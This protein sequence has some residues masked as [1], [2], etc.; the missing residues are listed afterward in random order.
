M[1]Q[2]L[3]DVRSRSPERLAR[4]FFQAALAVFA[5]AAALAW[6]L[7]ALLPLP[8]AEAGVRFPAAF[9]VSSLLLWLGSF[10]LHRAVWQVRRERQRPFRRALLAALAAG[11][12]FI[13]VQSFG[14]YGLLQQRSLANVTTGAG[15]FVFV[16]AFASGGAVNAVLNALGV[17]L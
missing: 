10:L 17:R 3:S 4:R 5:V 15:A 9:W 8:A 7:I 6:L 14:L 2:R 11:T 12:L 16:F 1:E 13:G